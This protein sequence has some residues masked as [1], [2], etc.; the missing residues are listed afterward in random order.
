VEEAQPANAPQ[1][2]GLFG[3]G[4]SGPRPDAP[5]GV[6]TPDVERRRWR[7]VLDFRARATVL[8]TLGVASFSGLLLVVPAGPSGA[9]TT[10]SSS[11]VVP[12]T[13]KG[14]ASSSSGAP[15]TPN[16]VC[17]KP[18]LLDGPSSPPT[19][20]VTVAPSVNLP[21]LVAAD[22]PGT[23]FWLSP[24]TYEFGGGKYSQV[25]PKDGDRF[26]GAPGAVLNGEHVNYYAF[27][28][29]ATN[30]T[31]E[32][33]TVKNF[34]V[35]GGN[36]NQGVVN[37]D[38]GNGWIVEHDTIRDNAGAGVMLGSGDVVEFNCLTHNGQY[39][40]S[41]YSPDGVSDVVVSDNEI[42][43]N[44]T[45]GYDTT[46]GDNCGCAGGGKFWATVGATVTGNYVHNN[47]DPGLWV[48]TDN[49]GFNISRNYIAHNSA[50]GL[51][52]EISYN[53]Q[54]ADNTF[55]DNAWGEGPGQGQGF[56]TTALYISES[57]SD[58][59]VKSAYNTSFNVVGNDFV[60]NRGGVVLWENANR[61]CSDGS[62]HACTLVNPTTFTISSCGGHLG[63]SNTSQTPDYYDGC[64]WKTQ[65]VN[66][67]DN[68]FQLSARDV[69]D[70]TEANGCGFNGI[71]SEY[72]SSVPFQGTAVEDHITFNQNNHF[73]HNTYIGPWSFMVHEQRT[74]VTWKEW[75]A[76]PYN[77]DAGSTLRR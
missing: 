52:Y 37:H 40:F 8:G 75:R 19:G 54:I 46:S 64:R 15:R 77:Q 2:G 38:S 73:S 20:A 55:V 39:G 50:E 31:V 58:P 42:S 13:G 35:R 59:R 53:A 41:A 1:S 27:T 66:V 70:C 24:G 23:T 26:I 68:R 5:T 63:P 61:F 72:G 17:G 18:A 45:F 74:V 56:P 21:N 9:A 28:Q 49:A 67:S 10:T 30:V 25:I 62:D 76:P 7:S 32:Y 69:P 36:N 34:G 6:R 60:D 51:I 33:L 14:A 57:G 11:P 48:D 12:S 43:Y 44:D 65:N 47:Q 22:P 16:R 29:H 3:G 4:V 71:F